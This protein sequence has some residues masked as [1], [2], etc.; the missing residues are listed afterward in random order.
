MTHFLSRTTID[1]FNNCRSKFNDGARDVRSPIKP[2]FSR[3]SLWFPVVFR[4]GVF[5]VVLSVVSQDDGGLVLSRFSPNFDQFPVSNLL[6]VKH[7]STV[8]CDPS[9]CGHTE[10]KFKS[11]P[12]F[13]YL[14]VR[15]DPGRQRRRHIKI[16][17]LTRNKS[18]R[19][20]SLKRILV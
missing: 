12:I 18:E 3:Y 2:I 19:L 11:S 8:L 7:C 4:P 17:F 14:D 13:L 16:C 1:S 5:Q 9:S 10:T 20:R 6:G 15:L